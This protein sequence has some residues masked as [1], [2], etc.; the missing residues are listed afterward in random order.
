M[1]LARNAADHMMRAGISD[2]SA[3]EMKVADHLIV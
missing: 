2:E 1:T 3:V